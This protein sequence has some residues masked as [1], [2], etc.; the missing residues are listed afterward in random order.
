MKT[1]SCHINNLK[2]KAAAVVPQCLAGCK[3]WYMLSVM[4]KVTKIW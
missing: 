2:H 1:G 3:E 4:W